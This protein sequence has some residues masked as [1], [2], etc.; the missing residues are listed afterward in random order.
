M[1]RS[2]HTKKVPGCWTLRMNDIGGPDFSQMFTSL[3]KLCGMGLGTVQP[4]SEQHQCCRCRHTS[5]WP[6]S[7]GP[8]RVWFRSTSSGFEWVPRGAVVAGRRVMGARVAAVEAGGQRKW[9][10]QQGPV[11]GLRVVVGST[12][13]KGLETFLTAP[14]RGPLGSWLVRRVGRRRC[15]GHWVCLAAHRV[16]IP[17]RWPHHHGVYDSQFCGVHEGHRD[18]WSGTL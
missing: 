13:R 9:G 12:G 5:V 8:P 14:E 2:G 15:V 18:Q 10:A 3:G 1:W 7:R 17:L 4:I 16:L 11:G 6:G